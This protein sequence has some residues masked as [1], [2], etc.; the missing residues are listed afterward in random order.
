MKYNIIKTSKFHLPAIF[1][2]NSWKAWLKNPND[3]VIDC[4]CLGSESWEH[5]EAA[6]IR[7]RQETNSGRSW[8]YW[9]ALYSRILTAPPAPAAAPTERAR[10]RHTGC[11]LQPRN[12]WC[13]FSRC[14][15]TISGT[16]TPTWSTIS[17]RQATE[18]ALTDTPRHEPSADWEA[19]VRLRLGAGG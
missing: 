12:H 3:F 13:T 17:T 16:I 9:S 6:P 15:W 1:I 11:W 10:H 18:A 19:E 5:R 4:A 8:C 7:G 14:E 2:T